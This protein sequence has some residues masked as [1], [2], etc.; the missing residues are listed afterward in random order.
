MNVLH[1]CLSLN[2]PLSL[3]SPI[4]FNEVEAPLFTHLFFS[5]L[6]YASSVVNVLG[7]ASRSLPISRRRFCSLV[8]L[9]FFQF[10][11]FFPSFLL[12]VLVRFF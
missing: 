10:L 12:S 4:M 8:F 2:S 11:S 6:W 9:V 7:Q 5:P 3:F 1:S